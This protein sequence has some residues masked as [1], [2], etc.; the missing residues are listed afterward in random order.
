MNKTYVIPVAV[1]TLLKMGNHNV[2]KESDM[3]INLN[4]NYIHCKLCNEELARKN[5]EEHIKNYHMG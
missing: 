5:M 4:G 3:F 1:K 2:M